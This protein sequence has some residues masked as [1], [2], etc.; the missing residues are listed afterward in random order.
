[1]KYTTSYIA[2]LIVTATVLMNV[3]TVFAQEWRV[4]LGQEILQ[5]SQLPQTSEFKNIEKPDWLATQTPLLKNTPV[6]VVAPGPRSVEPITFDA[7]YSQAGSWEPISNTAR[8]EGFTL[9]SF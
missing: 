5:G 7:D 8:N 9:F 3:S 1:M 2:A 4:L 6:T